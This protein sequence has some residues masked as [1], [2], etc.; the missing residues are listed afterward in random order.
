[1]QKLVIPLLLLMV[2]IL[3][4]N[5]DLRAQKL[6]VGDQVSSLDLEEYLQASKQHYHYEDLKDQALVLAFWAPWHAPS[7]K[8]IPHLNNL[9][10]QFETAPIRFISI[11]YE[12]GPIIEHFLERHTIKG[13]VG[14][15]RNRSVHKEFGIFTIPGTVLISPSGKVAAVTRPE[16]VNAQI[17][18]N[19]IQGNPIAIQSKRVP[20]YTDS[21]RISTYNGTYSST[22][23]PAHDLLQTAYRY[24]PSR[25]IAP[26][27]ILNTRL[28]I[29]IKAPETANNDLYPVIQ[30]TLKNA[31]GVRIRQEIRTTDAYVLTAPDGVTKGLRIYNS[32]II[33]TSAAEG[34]IA[35][36]GAPIYGLVKQLEEVL[37]VPVVDKTNFRDNYVWVVTFDGDK[38]T[39]VVDSVRKQ[40]GLNLKLEKRDIEMLV[41][42]SKER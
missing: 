33:R 19:L 31:L 6:G 8:W 14:L 3:T 36:S 17:L 34:V 9:Y 22:S 41:V 23:I 26:D 40:L 15:D 7:I 20:T 25:I 37:K 24:S 10:K 32:L 38:P 4:S 12:S 13:W 28:N 35:A 16:E 29:S 30:N 1:M 42:E 2:S 18:E 39:S 5:N 27:S 21:S 11:T